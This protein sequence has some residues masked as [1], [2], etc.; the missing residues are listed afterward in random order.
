MRT[1][2]MERG[3]LTA[4]PIEALVVAIGQAFLLLSQ[5]PERLPIPSELQ[6]REGIVWIASVDYKLK[7]VQ[8]T[9]KYNLRQ[10]DPSTVTRFIPLDTFK[11]I[12]L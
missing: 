4:Y 12:A 6:D 10:G 11:K 2:T 3:E 1:Q 5:L 8:L 7:G 9:K